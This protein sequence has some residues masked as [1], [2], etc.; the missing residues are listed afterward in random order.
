MD[1]AARDSGFLERIR[2]L[3]RLPGL[4]RLL[5]HVHVARQERGPSV[6]QR[7]CF[8]SLGMPAWRHAAAWTAVLVASLHDHGRRRA[9]SAE[10]RQRS[11][12]RHLH[13]RRPGSGLLGAGQGLQPGHHHPHRLVRRR[14]HRPRQQPAHQSQRD[15]GASEWHRRGRVRR[16]RRA[17]QLPG[18]HGCFRNRVGAGV[19]QR[20]GQQCSDRRHRY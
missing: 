13:R 6:A 8:L 9:A 4:Q 1:G 10:L 14:L 2:Q 18:A 12:R 15:H 20:R 5:S 11:Q 16:E 3:R 7:V 17:N 19:R